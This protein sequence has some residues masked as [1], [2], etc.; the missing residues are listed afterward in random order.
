MRH[1]FFLFVFF[2]LSLSAATA[3][4]KK[5]DSLETVLAGHKKGDTIRLRLLTHLAEGYSDIDP[6]KGL[7]FADKQLALATILDKKSSISG[8]YL[9]KAY[10]HITL[11]EDS[12][13]LKCFQKANEIDTSIN[14]MDGQASSLYGMA[15]VFQNRGDYQ[16]ALEYY[17]KSY[18]ILES[19]NNQIKM[20][21][22]HNGI[23]IVQMFLTDYQRSLESFLKSLKLYEM[24]G[25]S[26][27]VEAATAIGNIGLVYNRMEKNLETAIQYHERAL[28]IYRKNGNKLNEANTLSNMAN[29]YDNL[30]QPQK[31]IALQQQAYTI[32]EDVGSQ[33]GMANALTS[34][35]IAYTDIDYNKTLEYLKRTLPLQVEIHNKHGQA[36]ALQYL[37]R[38]LINLPAT[39][40]SLQE[41]ENYLEQGIAISK[42]L[43]YLQVESDI[44][45]LLAL[46]YTKKNDYKKA[47]GYKIKAIQ[48]KDS[49]MSQENL[50]K[51]TRLEEQYKYEKKEADIIAQHHKEQA[52]AQAEIDKQ[53]LIKI[54][55]FS[56]GGLLLLSGGIWLVMYKRKRDAIEK[57]HEAEYKAT[58]AE[59]ELKALRAQMNPHFIFN[60]LNSIGDY[61]AKNDSEKAKHYLSKFSKIMRQTLEFS[62]EKEI[63]LKEDL[64]LLEHYIQMERLRMGNSFHYS[65]T[66]D[67]QID[68]QNTMVPPMILQPF[69]EN[70]IW[71]GISKKEGTG[72]INIKIKKEN[73]MLQCTVDDN[74]V[75]ITPNADT[76]EL[77]KSLGQNITRK[78]IDIINKNKQANGNV[79]IRNKP[80]GQGVVVEVRLPLETAF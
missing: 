64:S 73:D 30:G 71:H 63:S 21:A 16:K 40:S 7:E 70:S 39:T 19:L 47:Y 36:I 27:S 8:A 35:G 6:K 49:I 54:S 17:Q 57:Q 76:S 24:N 29:A 59:T 65:I 1:A 23:G 37:G 56:G 18:V 61:V 4:Q 38:A 28:K 9:N 74:G 72:H 60:S 48:L 78:R 33:R 51:I 10:N 25:M 20:A 75:G 77:K 80:D 31:A 69:V 3:Q 79:T 2:G 66:V 45:N 26:E 44:N 42:E 13:A 32:F 55:L 58:V 67:A 62:N 52:V 53:K 46:L 34:I 15:W 11:S 14:D 50:D 41:A 12:L 68:Q 43:G 5:M 22:L